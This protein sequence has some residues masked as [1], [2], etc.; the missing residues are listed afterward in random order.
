MSIT[1]RQYTSIDDLHKIQ[2]ATADWIASAGFMG[3]LHIQAIA[4]LDLR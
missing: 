3:Y 2:S 1:P 4:L